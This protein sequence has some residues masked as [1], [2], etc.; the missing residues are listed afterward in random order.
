MRADRLMSLLLLLQSSKGRLK[1]RELARR[2]EVCERTVHRDLEA[3]SGSGVPVFADRGPNG[4]AALV[5]GW[6]TSVAGLTD[7]EAQALAIGAAPNALGKLG[8][9]AP[10]KSGLLKL[11]ASLPALQRRA[12]DEARQRLLIDSRPWFESDE[13]LP[14][15]GVLRDAVWRERKL[16]L[17]Y[18]DFDGNASRRTV[19]PYALVVKLDR[20]YLVA[21]TAAGPTVFRASRVTSARVLPQEFVR[22]AG[23]ELERFW[24]EWCRRFGQKRSSF[25]VEL[26]VS[27]AGEGLLAA[28]RPPADAAVIAGAR[29]GRDGRKRLTLDFE[30]KRIAVAQLFEMAPAVE[31]L[32]PADLRERLAHI[33]RGLSCYAVSAAES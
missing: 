26:A 24:A 28:V 18:R 7:A 1:A 23:F 12:A 9:S 4:G 17:G 29:R 19:D 6:R 16:R 11:A 30:K 13:E 3:L 22:P 5:E 21:G 14:H 20:L 27:P 2:L 25:E 15:L 32:Q 33:G 31:V 8:L 10:M